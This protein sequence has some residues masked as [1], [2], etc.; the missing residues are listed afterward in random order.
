MTRKRGRLDS[1]GAFVTAPIVVAVA[2]LVGA[3]AAPMV[4]AGIGGRA[5]VGR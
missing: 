2:L 3:S 4:Y 5:T 1:L